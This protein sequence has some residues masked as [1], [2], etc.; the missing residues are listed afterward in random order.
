[1]SHS[2]ETLE[3]NVKRIQTSYDKE[4]TDARRV[5]DETAKEKAKLQMEAGQLKKDFDDLKSK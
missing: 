2:E 5:V 1:M 3:R 4:L